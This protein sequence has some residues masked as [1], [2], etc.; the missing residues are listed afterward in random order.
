MFTPPLAILKI[1]WLFGNRLATSVKSGPRRP[2]SSPIKWQFKQP[3]EWNNCAPIKTGPL[4]A[5]ITDNARGCALKLGDHGDL[6]PFT[7][8]AA[9]IRTII[10]TAAMAHGRRLGLR[11]PR[12][13]MNGNAIKR[14]PTSS[15][16]KTMKYF[17]LPCGNKASTA[18]Y[19]NKYQSGRGLAAMMLGSGGFPNTGAPKNKASAAM[20]TIIPTQ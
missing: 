11:S 16:P 5:P 9:I 6:T 13:E 15:G 2:P 19:H 4:V 10:T 7:H 12:L 18:K 8:N 1:I 3:L 20:P 14:I 17:S